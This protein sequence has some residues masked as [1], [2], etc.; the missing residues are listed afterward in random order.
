MISYH[1]LTIH[2]NLIVMLVEVSIL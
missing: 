2:Y 1:H